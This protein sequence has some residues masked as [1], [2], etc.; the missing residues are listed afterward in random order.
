MVG[1]FLTDEGAGI[2]VNVEMEGES[3]VDIA[4]R[5]NWYVLRVLLKMDP[6]VNRVNAVCTPCLRKW[7]RISFSMVKTRLWHFS[8]LPIIKIIKRFKTLAI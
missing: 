3:L 5:T 7:Y 2:D 4:I 6:D 8:K 1:F